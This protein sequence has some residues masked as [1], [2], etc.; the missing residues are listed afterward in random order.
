MFD[1]AGITIQLVELV[2]GRLDRPIVIPAEHAGL[3]QLELNFTLSTP[4]LTELYKSSET[5]EGR[6]TRTPAKARRFRQVS[7]T[8]VT[9]TGRPSTRD[10][11]DT[12]GWNQGCPLYGKSSRTGW[13]NP[14]CRR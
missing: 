3:L 13:R 14:P 10:S 11:E 4:K 2:N 7:W 5:R 9:R 12:P 6:Y 8:R 1:M